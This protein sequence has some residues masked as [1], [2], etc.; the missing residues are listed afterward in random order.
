MRLET[1][2]WWKLWRGGLRRRS[3]ESWSWGRLLKSG[4]SPR[5]GKS[6]LRLVH[7]WRWWQRR[8]EGWLRNRLVKE[9]LLRSRGG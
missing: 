9:R 5:L 8:V 4:R 3:L 7:C 6:R 1:G 2:R